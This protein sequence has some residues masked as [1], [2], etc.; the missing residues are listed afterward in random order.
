LAIGLSLVGSGE[1]SASEVATWLEAVVT[2]STGPGLCAGVLIDDQGTVATAYH[3]VA[4]GRRP[5]VG[6]RDGTETVG[7]IIRTSPR[8]D[9]A[10]LAVPELAGRPYL[11]LREDPLEQGEEVWALGHPYG[12]A[13]DQ[14]PALAGVLRWSVSRGI[15]SAVG[16]R[17]I[18]VDAA[19]NPG[20][21][22]GPVVDSQGR[23]IGITSRK[24]RADNIGFLAPAEAL[25][26]LWVSEKRPF[27]VGG[28]YGV[29]LVA[30]LPTDFGTAPSLGVGMHVAFRD[31]LVFTANGAYALGANWMAAEQGS[32]RWTGLEILGA[33][34]IRVGRGRFSTSADLGGGMALEFGRTGA[35][36]EGQLQMRA[37]PVSAYPEAFARVELFGVAVR[38]AEVRH[39]PGDWVLLVALESGL[40]GPLGTF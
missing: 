31:S 34:R 6:T 36:V 2:V 8:D 16:T 20:N 11:A 29:H 22:G 5:H 21:S 1:A 24:L 17:V 28:S 27:P 37:G 25:A 33:G 26:E 38:V 19:V 18:Q 4:S 3:C 15:V 12:M 23:I 39:G 40:G 14:S 13:A 9:L 7:R 10:I 35:V 32:A 30:L